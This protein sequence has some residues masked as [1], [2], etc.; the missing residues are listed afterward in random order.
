MATVQ[1]I[2]PV[3]IAQFPAANF[4]QYLR[5]VGTNFPVSSLAYDAATKET[6]FWKLRASNYGSGNLTLDIDWYADTATTGDVV[7]GAQIAAITPDTDTQDVETKAF[8]TANTVTDSH[9]GTTGQR[10]HRA[11]LTISNLD[12]LAANDDVCI[13]IYR[14]AAAGADTMAGDALLA[15]ATLSYSDT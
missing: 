14:D 4:P 9:L 2:L 3:E 7:W 15:L 8:A 11:T 1:Q 5:I 10:L 6:A 13:A 12:S